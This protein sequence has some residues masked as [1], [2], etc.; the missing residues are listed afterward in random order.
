[1]NRR[2]FCL[3]RWQP[4]TYFFY[5][6]NVLF[7]WIWVV[8]CWC[9]Y[10]SGTRCRLAYGPADATATHCLLLQYNPVWFCLSGTGPPGESWKKGRWTG[11]CVCVFTEFAFTVQVEHKKIVYKFIKY[12]KIMTSLDDWL[13]SSQ[14]HH[15]RRHSTLH[16]RYRI[17]AVASYGHVT[18]I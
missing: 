8:R 5:H 17:V 18:V 14:S 1:M 16:G 4:R 7:Y 11:V 13:V 3:Q 9:S 12:D 15:S 2:R 10:L 6:Y